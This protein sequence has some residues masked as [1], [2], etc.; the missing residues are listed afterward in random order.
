MLARLAATLVLVFLVV[1]GASMATYR[2]IDEVSGRR[3]GRQAAEQLAARYQ[4]RLQARLT[5]EKSLVALVAADPAI[6]AWV[7]DGDRRADLRR[8]GRAALT[9]MIPHTLDH[10]PILNMEI[11]GRL[12]RYTRTPGLGIDSILLTSDTPMRPENSWFPQQ[13]N[14][15]TREPGRRHWVSFDFQQPQNRLRA[16]VS[17]PVRID[18]GVG[19]CHFLTAQHPSHAVS[20]HARHGLKS[21]KDQRYLLKLPYSCCSS[22]TLLALLIEASIF[23]LFLIMPSLFKSFSR[24]VSPY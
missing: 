11:D 6:R 23:N 16:W 9:R 2:W 1:A 18:G 8:A 10:Q 3:A 5:H 22:N 17:A 4:D 24:L 19:C 13:L 15:F 12:R 14:A 20:Q 7:A 21:V